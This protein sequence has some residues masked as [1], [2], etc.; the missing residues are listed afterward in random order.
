MK[1]LGGG[2]GASKSDACFLNT[3]LPSHGK[4]LVKLSDVSHVQLRFG[5]PL[6]TMM[7]ITTQANPAPQGVPEDQSGHAQV[8]VGER[9]LRVREGG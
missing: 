8:G 6:A 2:G 1:T 7:S 4:V 9:E 3:Y 5:I